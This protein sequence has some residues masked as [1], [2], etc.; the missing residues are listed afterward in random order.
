[1]TDARRLQQE[2]LTATPQSANAQGMAGAD[3]TNTTEDP[4]ANPSGD[5]AYVDT[6][7]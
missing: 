4:H 6:H 7:E 3:V 1:M 5:K 2:L